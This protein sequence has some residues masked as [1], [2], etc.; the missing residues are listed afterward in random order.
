MCPECHSVKQEIVELS[1]K[2]A[3]YTWIRP[4]HPMPYGFSEPPIVATVELE[5]G[6]R[7]VS[8]LVGIEFEKVKAG[9]PVEVCFEPTMKD[10]QVPVFRP[11]S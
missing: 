4:M 6:F 7:L 11:Q 3:V 9:M 10:H 1:G 8:N 2:G 5:E